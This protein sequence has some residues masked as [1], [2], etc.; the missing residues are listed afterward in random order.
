MSCEEDRQV[1]GEAGGSAARGAA[2]VCEVLGPGAG[3]LGVWV[4]P[5][6]AAPAQL[7]GCPS[8][9]NGEAHT[10]P[11]H[12]LEIPKKPSRSLPLSRGV[13]SRFLPSLLGSSGVRPGTLTVRSHSTRAPGR[14]GSW[15]RGAQLGV[16]AQGGDTVQRPARGCPAAARGPTS[17]VCGLSSPLKAETRAAVELSM[18]VPAARGP[19]DTK[20]TR[21][22]GA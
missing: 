15:V 4:G 8:Q 14:G 13:V 18:P 6:A 3:G 2:G 17:R 1:P 22:E 10:F 12:S 7:L 5:R 9:A 11:R 20:R 19:A 21:G 16:R